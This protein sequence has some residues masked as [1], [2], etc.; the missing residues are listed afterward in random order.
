MGFNPI[1]HLP[2]LPYFILLQSISPFHIPSLFSLS[3][4]TTLSI[5]LISLYLSS[6]P[7]IFHQGGELRGEHGGVRVG[8]ARQE[9]SVELNSVP[10]IHA[11]TTDPRYHIK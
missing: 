1:P 4:H 9:L 10:V 5:S 8:L 6:S 3:H 7:L 11:T 2:L